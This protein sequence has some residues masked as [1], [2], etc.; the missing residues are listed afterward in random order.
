MYRVQDNELIL[1]S[2]TSLPCRTSIRWASDGSIAAFMATDNSVYLW[3]TNG[4]EPQ[5]I[6]DYASAVFVASWSPDSSKLA[7]EKSE[8]DTRIGTMD[9]FDVSGKL[10]QEFQFRVGGDVGPILGWLTDDVLVSYARY[11][12]GQTTWYYGIRT[13]HLLFSWTSVPTGNG[14]F[15]VY[16]QVSPDHRWV[17]IDQGSEMHESVLD[18]NRHIVQKEYSLYDIQGERRYLLLNDW[19]GYLDYA[20][21]NTNSS[22]LYVVNRPSESVSV[23]AQSTPFG[24]LGYDVQTQQY[25]LLFKDAVWVAWNSDKS[26][27]FVVFAAQDEENQLGLAGG[28]WQVGSTALVGQW[29]IPGQMVYQDPAR[30]PLSLLFP[31]F[32]GSISIAWSHD[33]QYVAVSDGFGHVK[34]LGLDGAEHILTDEMSA[35]GVE[36]CWSPDDQQLLVSTDIG[37]WIVDV[38]N[39]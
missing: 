22:V 3:R 6:M 33:D 39:P 11:N 2:E 20:G 12:S 14:V 31:G 24:L 4:E 13:G 7:V 17:F 30:D 37:A 38:S 32:P 36:L 29:P 28:L 18:P 21:W 8:T 5:K 15:H 19:N 16:P 35:N 23:S 26:W 34:L 10:L 1:I 27:A 9:I 25:E